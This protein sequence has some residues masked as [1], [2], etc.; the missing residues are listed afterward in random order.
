MAP[1]ER[2]R[3]L[4]NIWSGKSGRAEETAKRLHEHMHRGETPE[5]TRRGEA[6]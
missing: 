1:C 3:L 6:H 4:P 5:T 2:K